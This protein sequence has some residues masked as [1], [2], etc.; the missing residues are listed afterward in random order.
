MVGTLADS[1]E[2]KLNPATTV[3]NC[4]SYDLISILGVVF[5]S[6]ALAASLI[7]GILIC[8]GLCKKIDRWL[9]TGRRILLGGTLLLSLAVILLLAALATNQFQIK[10]VAQYSSR[11]LPF[12]LKLT[13][14][15]AGQEGSLLLWAFLQTLFAS[16]IAAKTKVEGKPL[17]GWAVVILSFIAAFFIGMTLFFSN[18]FQT[19][20]PTPLDGQ[21]MN[22]LL[23]HPGMIFHPPVLYIGYVGLSVPFAYA[24]SALLVGEVTGWI[25]PVRRWLLLSWIALGWGI[26]LGARWA[27]DVL[28]WGGYWGWDPVE[29]AGLM[30]WLIATAFLHGLDMQARGKGFKVWNVSLAVLSFGLVLFGTFTTR[31]GLIE[32]VHAFSISESGPYY[33]G[34]IGLVMIGSLVLMILRRESFGE[35]IYPEKIFSR[36]GAFFFTLLLITLITLS[37]LLGT[38]LPTLTGG[39]FSAPP[40]WFNQVVGPQLAALV[41]LMGFCPLLGNWFQK[42]RSLW[43][44]LPPFLG[45]VLMTGVS[46]WLGFTKP[47][48]LVGL[49]I[50]GFAGGSA[51]EEIGLA[52]SPLIRQKKTGNRIG[53][54]RLG[55]HLVHLGIVLMAVG[56]I[57]TQLY[58]SEQTLTF[59]PGERVDLGKYELL[60][61]DLFQET[62]NDHLD[63]WINIIVYK[64]STTLTTLT[65][66]ILYYPAYQQTM[67]VPS[68]HAGWVEDLYLVL[69]R[70]DTNSEASLAVAVNPL[71]NFLWLGGFFLLMGG[72]VAWWP[73]PVAESGQEG[74]RK[75]IWRNVSAGVVLVLIVLIFITLW[76]NS[77][78]TGK[79]SARPL[80]GEA[81]IAFSANEI[82]GTEFS[83]SDYDGDVIVVHFWATWC[84]QCENEML[85]LESLWQAYQG[86]DVQFIGIAMDDAVASVK[87]LAEDL[88]ISFPLIVEEGN[89][90]TSLYGVRAVPETFII[91]QGGAV[92]Y[93]HIGTMESAA[94]EAELDSLLHQ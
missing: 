61:E 44:L 37:I 73:G 41:L 3:M 13:A 47:V 28:G 75:Q 52:F 72:S 69:F 74:R 83:L 65:P 88:Q 12:Y 17:D 24:I 18:P 10:A 66:K 29:N 5:I 84:D 86:Q 64:D 58:A 2:K 62:T 68:V 48:A 39:R 14:I 82:F 87:K 63:T 81:A 1:F 7:A 51:L 6:I 71:I 11:D 77:L 67:A 91:D 25:K 80:P 42:G 59:S 78:Q 57:G 23:R 94:L 33:L 16:I 31:S 15:W 35:L 21:G 26:F 90:I 38:L 34:M 9:V 89:A 43:R 79:T 19:I 30:P 53:W 40:A 85:M 20:S 22:P 76:G 36:E 92:A 55:A 50:A 60:Y 32:S 46:L 54:K 49:A 45:A 4:R 70:L 56:V 8:L 27:Y 93:F